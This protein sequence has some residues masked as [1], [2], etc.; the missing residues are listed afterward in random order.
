MIEMPEIQRRMAKA[1]SDFGH[2]PELFVVTPKDWQRYYEAFTQEIKDT[3]DRKGFYVVQPAEEGRGLGNIRMEK[4]PAKG[5]VLAMTYKGVPVV[6]L[7][8]LTKVI[9]LWP[10][11]H[12]NRIL[13]L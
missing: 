3:Y 9:R 12:D 7:S 4:R 5:A 8:D 10:A 1:Y 11:L 2:T 13:G 6:K